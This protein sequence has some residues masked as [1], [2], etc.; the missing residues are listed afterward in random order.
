MVPLAAAPP[1]LA[2]ILLT[3]P[4]LTI[5]KQPSQISYEVHLGSG[6]GWEGNVQVRAV[7]NG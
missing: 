6:A 7:K 5:L 2:R 3:C 4:F 1:A